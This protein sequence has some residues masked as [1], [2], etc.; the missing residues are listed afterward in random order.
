[1]VAE[2]PASNRRRYAGCCPKAPASV[3]QCAKHTTSSC[4][5]DLTL[6]V[7]TNDNAAR[8]KPHSTAPRVHALLL[9]LLPLAPRLALQCNI[10]DW[11]HPGG[12]ADYDYFDEDQ[13]VNVEEDYFYYGR[14]GTEQLHCV[15]QQH[16]PT[17]RRAIQGQGQGWGHRRDQLRR[18][19]P[20]GAASSGRVRGGVGYCECRGGGKGAKAAGPERVRCRERRR[21]ERR[22]W[23]SA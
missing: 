14:P 7:C 15:R 19:P 8:C 9:T 11:R 20:Q 3:P 23:E 10:D 13:P 21:W 6:S 12:Y 17:G 18:K 22:G 1:M 5:M 16:C 2:A 4:A